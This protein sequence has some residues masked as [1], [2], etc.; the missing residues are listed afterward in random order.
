VKVRS[1]S[2]P[3]GFADAVGATYSQFAILEKVAV[4][5]EDVRWWMELLEPS[6]AP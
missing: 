2:Q 1:T 5:G 4:K 3:G 6:T